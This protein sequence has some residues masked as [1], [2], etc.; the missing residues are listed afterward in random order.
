MVCAGRPTNDGVEANKK[1]GNKVW[2][3]KVF[4]MVRVCK[5]SGEGDSCQSRVRRAYPMCEFYPAAELSLLQWYE[6]FEK[7]PSNVDKI[8]ESLSCIRLKWH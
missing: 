1:F 8:N 2:Y 6:I 4:A 5:E 7:A 3:G